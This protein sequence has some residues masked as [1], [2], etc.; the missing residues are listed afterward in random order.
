VAGITTLSSNIS[1]AGGSFTTTNTQPRFIDSTGVTRVGWNSSADSFFGVTSGRSFFFQVNGSNVANI[2]PSGSVSV[3]PT[4]ANVGSNSLFVSKDIP[5]SNITS[6]Q[7][8]YNYAQVA[9]GGNGSTARLYLGAAYTGGE[10]AGSIIQSSDYFSSTDNGVALF[11]NPKGGFVGVGSS[12]YP[13]ALLDVQGGHQANQTGGSNLIAFQYN[14]G[15]FRHFITSRHNSAV[16]V[17]T[18]AIDFW[19]N[20][21]TTS[22]GSSTAGTSN[23]NIFS[24]TAT[25]VG[26]N[27]ATP[28]YTLD[29][30]GVIQGAVYYSTITVGGIATVTPNNFGIFYN[31]TT[32]GTYTLAFSASQ[33]SS[34]IGKYVVFRNNSGVTL[35]LALTGVS[36]ITSPITLSNAQSATV[37]VATTSTYALF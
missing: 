2:G 18:N 19:L 27:T 24:A 35:S 37:V 36:G 10:G 26:I 25:G 6:N 9:I 3:G 31:I 8:P 17:N 7:N 29:V 13:L 1:F 34:N 16:G 5:F 22:G 11:L 33:A 21:T 32:S 4:T 12:N 23:V 30:N 14:T 28:G 15:G 20:N